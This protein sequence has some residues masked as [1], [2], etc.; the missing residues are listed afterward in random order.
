MEK[1]RYTHIDKLEKEIDQMLT[2]GKTQREIAAFF[3]FKDKTIV[4]QYLKRQRRKK[5]R[6]MAGILPKRRGR[7]P[8]GYVPTEEEKDNE[9]KRLKME[10]QLL[11]SFLQSA[12]RR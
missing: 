10:I 1:Q 3:G 2:E 11:R 7:L 4:H 12:G 6:V 9:I 8:N 5:E